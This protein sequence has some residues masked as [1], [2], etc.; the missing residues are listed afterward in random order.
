MGLAAQH[1]T[2]GTVYH[3]LKNEKYKGTYVGAKFIMPVPVNIGC[4]ALLWNSRYVLRT[5]MPPL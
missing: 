3:V 2:S 4:C 5:A 1:W